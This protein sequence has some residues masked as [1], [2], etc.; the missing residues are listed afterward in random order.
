MQ[1]ILGFFPPTNYLA[2][3]CVAL[4]VTKFIEKEHNKMNISLKKKKQ[5]YLQIQ[6]VFTKIS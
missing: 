3:Y 6:F 5:T 4:N 2:I 1:S